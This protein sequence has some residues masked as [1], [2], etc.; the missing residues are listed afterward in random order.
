MAANLQLLANKFL[1]Q[2]VTE[3]VLISFDWVTKE[4]QDW[5]V[6]LNYYYHAAVLPVESC[7]EAVT[8]QNLLC[9]GT[10]WTLQDK[11]E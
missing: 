8:P 10:R 6:R 11:H 3:L 7:V 1:Y 5:C 9:E 2:S 4:A